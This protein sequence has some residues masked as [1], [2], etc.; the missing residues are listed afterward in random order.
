MGIKKEQPH[1]FQKS[2]KVGQ[3]GEAEFMELFKDK[4]TRESGYLEDFTIKRTGKKL[5]LKTD[6]YYNSGNFFIEKY[7]YNK[8]PGGPDQAL[9]KNVDYF[10]FF[11]PA[12]MSIHCFKTATLAAYLELNYEKPYLINVRNKSHVTQGYLVKRA[13]LEH[14]EINIKDIL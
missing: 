3:K 2:L 6:S 9:S 11:F 14:L 7:S 8:V 12:T 1:D 5:E 4:L 10:V 13:D